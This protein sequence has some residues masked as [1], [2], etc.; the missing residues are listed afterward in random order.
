VDQ[1]HAPPPQAVIINAI[2]GFWLSRSV[3]L[4]ARLKIADAVG[5]AGA[6]LAAIAK[7][8]GTNVG[9]LGRLMRALAA[10]GIF[11]EETDGTFTQTPVSETLRSGR[12]GSMRAFAEVELGH[13]HYQ[14]W[15][16]VATCLQESGTAFE[17]IFGMPIWRYY[18][19]HPEL[20]ALFGEGMT[21]MTAMANAAVL[22]DYRLPDFHEAVDVGGGYG[23][24]LSA[25]LDR[26]PKAEGTLYDLPT[27]VSEAGR[28]DFV[29]RHNGRLKV[30]GG[31]FFKE[32]PAGGDL[33]LLKFIIHDWDDE[34]SIAI[35][36]NIRKAI[37]PKGRLT[38]VEM[39]LP[40]P[41]EPHVGT[42]LDLNMMVMTG[43]RE[44]TEKGYAD[45]FTKSGFRL[46]R[47]VATKSPFSVIEALPT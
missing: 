45:L 30:E 10:N 6:S 24:F 23:S 27:V 13:D 41:N 16:D 9:N 12:P 40:K 25:I 11:R 19:E 26:H 2:A 44:R 14:A 29:K 46:D 39:V 28:G 47:V 3:Y 17:R 38:L 37:A 15:G 31:D 20:E 34:R 4:A 32:V 42:L 22:G 33:Y 35:L 5:D 36:S 1:H 18:A 8:S 21:N 43:G 7:A